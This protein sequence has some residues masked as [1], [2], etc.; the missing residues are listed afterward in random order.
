MGYTHYWHTQGEGAAAEDFLKIAEDVQRIFDAAKTRGIELLRE[1]DEPGTEPQ[2]GEG[3]IYFNGSGDLGHETFYLDLTAI[4]KPAEPKPNAPNE[5]GDPNLWWD[6]YKWE[7]FCTQGYR[8]DFCKTARKPYDAAVCAVLTRAK[9][10][11]GDLISIHSDGR[12]A[13]WG[14]GLDLCKSV[15]GSATFPV[16]EPDS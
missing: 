6:W 2:I 8:F 9:Y 15:F 14:A 16:D 5:G 13:D 11:L 7:R 3:F 12:Q 4:R 1:F 10:R